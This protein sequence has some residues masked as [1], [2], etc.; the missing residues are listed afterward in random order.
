MTGT[1][2]NI[3]V[4]ITIGI[5]LD[6]IPLSHV[7]T[8]LYASVDTHLLWTLLPTVGSQYCFLH[9]GM[10]DDVR[11]KRAQQEMG[12]IGSTLGTHRTTDNLGIEAHRS[13]ISDTRIE[14]GSSIL[15][16]I[17]YKFGVQG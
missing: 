7:M 11:V 3:V 9:M 16:T 2:K 5:L 14:A 8:N 12:I 4:M 13:S 15:L 10:P 17:W 1:R 6:L